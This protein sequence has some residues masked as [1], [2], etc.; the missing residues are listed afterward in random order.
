MTGRLLVTSLVLALAGASAA[1][2]AAASPQ[3]NFLYVLADDLDFDYKQDRKAIMPNLKREMAEGGLEFR[4]HVAVVPVCGPSRSSLLAGRFPH[5]VGYVANAVQ[6]S[7]KAF[8]ALQNNTIGAWMRRSSWRAHRML[9][10]TGG[11]LRAM[12]GDSL[13][14]SYKSCDVSRSM[15]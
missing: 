7:V 3:P 9:P 1:A 13:L 11:A 6:A 12:G 8:R 14:R 2:A 10:A 15:P 5:N 4:N